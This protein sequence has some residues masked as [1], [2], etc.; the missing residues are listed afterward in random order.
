[1]GSRAHPLESRRQ[2]VVCPKWPELFPNC[3]C[4]HAAPGPGQ[5]P[6]PKASGEG[7]GRGVELLLFHHLPFQMGLEISNDLAKGEMGFGEWG[8]AGVCTNQRP[9]VSSRSTGLYC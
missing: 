7:V 8:R 2:P 5:K 3:H 6:A 4:S 1:M 9:L